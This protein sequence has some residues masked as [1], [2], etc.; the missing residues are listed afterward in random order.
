MPQ[1]SYPDRP[2]MGT[3]VRDGVEDTGFTA[4]R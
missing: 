2:R 3:G 1:V 4:G